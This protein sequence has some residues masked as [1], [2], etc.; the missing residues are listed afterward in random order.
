MYK[1]LFGNEVNCTQPLF[2]DGALVHVYAET[3]LVFNKNKY[4]I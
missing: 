1:C 4:I 2:P 3:G